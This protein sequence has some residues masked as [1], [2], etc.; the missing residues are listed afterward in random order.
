MA[1]GVVG[2][3]PQL[4]SYSLLFFAHGI[5]SS[6]FFLLI[7]L[8]SPNSL[9]LFFGRSSFFFFLKSE[10]ALAR[11][12]RLDAHAPEK[13]KKKKEPSEKKARVHPRISKSYRPQ[14]Q[15]FHRRKKNFLLELT[16]VQNT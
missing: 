5:C 1:Y 3:L 7:F 9:G 15:G 14:G 8:S 2:E 11:L 16:A 6:S 13:K 4:V 10:T 12:T